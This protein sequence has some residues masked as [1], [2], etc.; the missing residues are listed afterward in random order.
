MQESSVYQYIIEKG[1]RRSTIEGILE[2][3]DIRFHVNIEATL[4]SAIESIEDLQRLRQLRREAAQAQSLE[5]FIR[6]LETDNGS[7]LHEQ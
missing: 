1:E 2:L 7:V 6:T 5:S 3:L 4:K